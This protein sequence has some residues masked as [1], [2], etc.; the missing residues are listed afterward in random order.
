MN[1]ISIFLKPS[2]WIEPSEDEVQTIRELIGK[3]PQGEFTIVVR[4]KNGSPVV[5]ENSPFFYD[6]TPMPTRYWLVDPDLVTKISRLESHGGVK[7]VQDE[8]DFQT[9]QSIHTRHENQRNLL[10]GDNYEGPKP[11]G[12]VGGTRKGVKCL[13]THVA[14]YLATGDDVVGKWALDRIDAN[15]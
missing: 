3:S 15:E 5:I 1:P 11:T 14:N 4:A 12:G 6:G 7:Q 8:I 2:S 13:H 10:I 9:I